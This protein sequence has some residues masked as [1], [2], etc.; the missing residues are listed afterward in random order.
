MFPEINVDVLGLDGARGVIKN[1]NQYG[2]V[3][4]DIRF[5]R[6]AIFL[7]PELS[8]YPWGKI[9]YE[10]IEG[11]KGSDWVRAA[12]AGTK[13]YLARRRWIYLGARRGK[14]KIQYAPFL[15][16]STAR[17]KRKTTI[18]FYSVLVWEW[19]HQ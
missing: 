5:S 4:V 15:V 19:K 9:N 3:D 8:W 6:I 13:P 12:L 16:L 18:S 14:S 7:A 10:K 11:K 17:K 1:D 2:L